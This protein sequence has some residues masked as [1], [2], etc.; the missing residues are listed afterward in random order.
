MHLPVLVHNIILQI[1]VHIF[2]NSVNTSAQVVWIQT[3]FVWVVEEIDWICQLV[4]ARPVIL[5]MGRMK[6]VFN[7]VFKIVEHVV[8]M[9]HALNVCKAEILKITS[10]FVFLKI[11]VTVFKYSL[12][13]D[14]NL[15]SLLFFLTFKPLSK[16][17]LILLL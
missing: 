11:V 2:V 17:T 1:Q 15:T 14:F 12:T 8:I 6:I 3:L 13:S 10:V 7:V 5:K 4:N 9:E 16:P